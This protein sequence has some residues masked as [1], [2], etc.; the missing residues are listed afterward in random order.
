[1]S[2]PTGPSPEEGSE[3]ALGAST[4]PGDDLVPEYIRADVRRAEEA[5][6]ERARLEDER[7][8]RLD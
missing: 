6:A 2:L 4:L 3:H 1:M 8:N 7:R 5:A